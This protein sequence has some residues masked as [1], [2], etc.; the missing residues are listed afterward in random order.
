M[1]PIR[2]AIVDDHA[3]FRNV[4]RSALEREH[5][6]AVVAEADNGLDAIIM[7][8]NVRPAIVLMDLNLPVLNGF[9]AISVITEQRPTTKVI[10]LSMHTLDDVR[11]H[12]MKAG[13]SYYLSK[14]CGLKRLV[15]VI[16]TC[17]SEKDPSCLLPW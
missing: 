16:R 12:A 8:E 5:D 13:A 7:V 10:A 14:D 11:V 9:D 4:L 6:F 15:N 3:A 1:N 17:F 2:I